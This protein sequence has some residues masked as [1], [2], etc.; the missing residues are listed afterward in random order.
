MIRPLDSAAGESSARETADLL[1]QYTRLSWVLF[2]DHPVNVARRNQGKDPATSIWLW[3]PGRRPSMMTF[4]E[5]FGVS[6][7]VISAVDLVRGIGVYAGFKKI[8]VPGAT[9]LYDTNYE[10]KANACLEALKEVDFV[11]VHVEAPDEAGHE[12]NLELK[13]RTIEDL[14]QRLVRIFLEGIEKEGIPATLAVL[15]DHLTPVETRT[16]V[17]GA[18]PFAIWD[19]TSPR[20]DTVMRFDEESCREGSYGEIH[21]DEFIRSVLGQTGH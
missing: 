15:P 2:R 9:G 11:Y 18:V 21:G 10:G 20:T 14:D 3:S 13:V 8:L 1:N 19:K 6:G 12:G 7:A 4:G 5:R 16:H 17:R